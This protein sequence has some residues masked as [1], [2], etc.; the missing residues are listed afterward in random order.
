MLYKR[1]AEE[2]GHADHGWLKSNFSFSFADYYDENFMGFGP[3]RVINDDVVAAGKGFGMH[4]H[5]DMEI[6]TYVL[7]GQLEHKDSMGTG[8]II[9]PGDVQHMSAGTGVFHSEFNPSETEAVHLLQIWIIPNK[10][11]VQPR[12]A[13][14]YF[15][16]EEKQ[17]KLRLIAS[18][19]GDEGSV[20]IYQDAKVFASVLNKDE[21]VSYELGKDR[22]AW[23]QVALGEVKLNGM[24]LKAGDGVAVAEE[25]KLEIIGAS[26]GA[27]FILFDV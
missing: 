21:S 23:L 17:G 24:E 12:Y 1:P 20:E 13:Q 15:A 27:E 10:K 14:K 19:H 25:D 6:I 4:P 5:R 16:K 26:D 7:S 22:H 18:E 8:S 3:L 11:S 2:R 9:K